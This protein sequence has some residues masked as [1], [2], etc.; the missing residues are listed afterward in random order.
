MRNSGRLVWKALAVA[1]LACVLVVLG[2]LVDSSRVGTAGELADVRLG[3]PFEWVHQDHSSMD[4]PAGAALDLRFS[5]PQENP[6]HVS[7]GV[8]AV[9]L[10]LAS[11]AVVVVWSGLRRLVGRRGREVAVRVAA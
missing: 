8:F 4:P 1:A 11:A 2:L 9:N 3:L 6:T 7:V 5:L 10:A